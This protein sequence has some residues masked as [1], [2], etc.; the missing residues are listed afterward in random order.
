MLAPHLVLR[1]GELGLRLEGV[2]LVVH[3]EADP[4][5]ENRT[6]IAAAVHEGAAPHTEPM[7]AAT[8]EGH[9]AAC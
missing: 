5:K 4:V 8:E 1:G 9:R 6:G 3:S 2:E 7:E